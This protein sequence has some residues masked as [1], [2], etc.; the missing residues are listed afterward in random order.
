MLA[1][2]ADVLPGVPAESPAD[3]V[4]AADG[5]STAGAAGQI[6]WEGST[7][8]LIRKRDPSFPAVLSAS[9]QEVECEARINVT[10]AGSVSHVEISRSSGYIEIDASVEA[11]LHDYLF[12]RVDG[13]KDA[14]GTVRFRFRLEMQD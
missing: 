14:V 12:S 3:S 5:S 11:A 6:G 2:I 4:S 1:P 9:G 7:R 8:K 10:P 13:R